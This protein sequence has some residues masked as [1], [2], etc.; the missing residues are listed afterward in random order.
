MYDAIVKQLE[1]MQRVGYQAVLLTAAQES[2]ALTAL[3][4]LTKNLT[5]VVRERG[6][7]FAHVSWDPVVGMSHG[8]ARGNA[9]ITNA[10]EAIQALCSTERSDLPDWAVCSF[11]GAHAPLA[12][13]DFRRALYM[14]VDRQRLSCRIS[15]TREIHRF[16]VLVAPPTVIVPSDITC[17][18]PRIDL[19]LPG[20]QEHLRSVE[21]I[22][23]SIRD[24]DNTCEDETR[25]AIASSMLGLTTYEAENCLSM[26]LRRTKSFSLD[27]I[28]TVEEA[29]ASLIARNPAMTYTPSRRLPA[30]SS[31]AGFDLLEEWAR[32]QTVAY[33]QHAASIGIDKP[34][35][36]SLLGP[37]GTGK[38]VAAQVV[39]GVL[40]SPLI[41]LNFGALFGSL[42]GQSEAMV[43]E[44]VSLIR[45]VGKCVVL[46]DEAD[47][48]FSN[49]TDSSSHETTQRV[50]A[51]WL[52]FTSSPNREAF[53]IYALNRRKNVPSELMRPG[54]IDRVWYVDLPKESERKAI[55]DIHLRRR[56]IDPA[57]W[58]AA[59]WKKIIA[60]SHGMVGAELEECVK[61]ARLLALQVDPTGPAVPTVQQLL[62]VI[63]ERWPTRIAE[64]D[65]ADINDIRDF[66]KGRAA[67]VSSA[68]DKDIMTRA[69]RADLHVG[70]N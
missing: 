45:A 31:I 33:T 14:A 32:Q 39:A 56:G 42:V 1:D 49:V 40:G 22:R 38:S 15:E 43:R 35:G 57:L 69:R 70:D 41:T 29:K 30:P 27:I 4:Q 48:Y 64:V 3:I 68:E 53:V 21:E 6:H 50:F 10:A 18:L 52:K 37:P 63:K 7:K 8:S 66:C 67:P 23:S 62:S 5:S 26:G 17:Y 47:K 65:K 61:S 12:D 55:F 20:L 28:D 51:E 13:F 16:V 46:I 34:L 44:V 58:D 9:T 25:Y 19:P 54:R 60:E 24:V 36:C 59:A 2:Q 11:L